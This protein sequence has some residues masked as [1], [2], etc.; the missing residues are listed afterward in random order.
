MN[1]EYDQEKP[2][3]QTA[4]KPI[5]FIYFDDKTIGVIRIMDFKITGPRH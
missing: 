5:N 2:K 3:S 4:D 1:S